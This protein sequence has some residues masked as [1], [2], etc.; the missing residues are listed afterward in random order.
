MIVAEDVGLYKFDILGQRGLGK[1]KDGVEIIRR[2]NPRHQP[3]DIHDMKRFRQDEKVKELLR[4]G[5]A[6]GCFYVESPAMRML[7]A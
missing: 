6:I 1:I 2:N 4:W 5:K 7:V 3:I